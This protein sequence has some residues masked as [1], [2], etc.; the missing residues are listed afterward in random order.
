MPLSSAASPQQPSAGLD[1]FLASLQ[2]PWVIRKRCVM[3]LGPGTKEELT[4]LVITAWEG[5]KMFVV[6][7]LVDSMPERLEEMT[8]NE[9]D[10]ISY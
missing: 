5:I 10:P 9:A 1:A 6:N 3:E 2:K 8:R 7:K 4:E